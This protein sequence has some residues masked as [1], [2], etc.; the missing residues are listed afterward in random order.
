MGSPRNGSR[1]SPDRPAAKFD[2]VLAGDVDVRLAQIAAVQR[3]LAERAIK[4]RLLPF[5]VGPDTVELR[6]VRSFVGE[7]S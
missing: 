4:T 3:W 2:A 5:L 6:H 7:L 1:V